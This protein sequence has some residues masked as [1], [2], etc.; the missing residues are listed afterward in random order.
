MV[1]ESAQLPHIPIYSTFL[2]GCWQ[3]TGSSQR[4]AWCASLLSCSKRLRILCFVWWLVMMDFNIIGRK[5]WNPSLPWRA[6]FC[7][8]LDS[9]MLVPWHFFHGNC[10]SVHFMSSLRFRIAVWCVQTESATAKQAAALSAQRNETCSIYRTWSLLVLG[11]KSFEGQPVSSAILV[12]VFWS[13][14]TPLFTCRKWIWHD[15]NLVIT[16]VICGA[17]H[18]FPFY[19]HGS[20]LISMPD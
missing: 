14:R 4:R 9:A 20:D 19:Q 8:C 7:L 15:A 11:V 17:F 16:L 3:R 6:S 1:L 2:W 12:S 13:S 10:Q 5:N 18:S